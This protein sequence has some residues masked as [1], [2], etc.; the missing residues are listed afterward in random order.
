MMLFIMFV[1]QDGPYDS[2][3]KDK[4]IAFSNIN[5]VNPCGFLVEKAGMIFD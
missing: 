1:F 3:G 4:N 2:R 5:F